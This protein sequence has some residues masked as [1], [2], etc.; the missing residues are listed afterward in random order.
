MCYDIM[1][2]LHDGYED[3]VLVARLGRGDM[4]MIMDSMHDAHGR[5]CGIPF[6]YMC[7]ECKDRITP[8]GGV[9]L[10]GARPTWTFSKSPA[11]K[12]EQTCYSLS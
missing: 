1:D 7:R 4:L 9:H 10:L 8:S 3:G 12:S 11:E 2:L 5:G 6:V